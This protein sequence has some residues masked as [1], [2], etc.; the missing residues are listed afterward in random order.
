MSQ[1]HPIKEFL[2]GD[3]EPFPECH[4][5]TILELKDGHFMS[6]WFGGTKEKNDDV[7]IW[8]TKGKPGNWEK[9]IEV[10][11]INNDAHWNPVLFQAPGGRIYLFFKVGKTI[12]RW[13]TY[14]KTSEDEGK[15][16]SEARELVPG[17]YGGRGPVRSKLIILSNGTWLAGASDEQ[18]AWNTFFDRSEDGPGSYM[19]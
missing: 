16:W 19:P 15:T 13:Q 2:F 12:P 6:A 3:D 18:G 14:V 17:N 11:K 7:G 1:S 5:S 9:P 8:M 4:A 10:A